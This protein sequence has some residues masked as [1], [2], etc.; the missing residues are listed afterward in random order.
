MQSARQDLLLGTLAL[1]LGLL[2]STSLPQAGKPG[3]NICRS[4]QPPYNSPLLLHR[5]RSNRRP[6]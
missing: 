6:C 1:V 3:R 5:A 4:L 2:A